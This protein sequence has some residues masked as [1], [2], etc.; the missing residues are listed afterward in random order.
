MTQSFTYTDTTIFTV[1]HAQHIAA[2]V[3]TDLKRVQ[4]FYN[5]P[6]DERIGNY[7][8]ELIAMLKG[9]YV[10]TVT[11]G[12]RRNEQ[13]IEPTLRY[14][15]QELSGTGH[16]DDDPG[17]IKPGASV[18]GASFYSYMTYTPAYY[19]LT[20]AERDTLGKTLPFTRGDAPEPGVSGYFSS[21]Q[22]YSAGGRALNRSTVRS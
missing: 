16:S 14:T 9:K 22:M 8:R 1:T 5:H 6:T 13:W 20:Q 19:A 18:V 4:R 7:E 15:A 21:D 11:Y 17:K 2:K 10:E 3:A 12:F